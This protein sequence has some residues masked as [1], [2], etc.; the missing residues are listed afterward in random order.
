MFVDNNSL[1]ATGSTVYTGTLVGAN[2]EFIANI[3]D[4]QYITFGQ[5][6]G[7]TV[8]PTIISISR[9]SGS[10]M[11][12]GNFPLIVTYSD[13]GSNI[14]TASFTGKIYAWDGVS[15]WGATNLAPTYMTLS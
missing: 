1:F 2:W 11:P 5:A 12:I 8:A 7:D 9:S 13:T 3:A 6:A 4:M 14:N 10:L 15:A